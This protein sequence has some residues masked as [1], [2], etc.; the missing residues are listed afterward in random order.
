[1]HTFVHAQLPLHAES[2]Q[3]PLHRGRSLSVG[4][5]DLD[6]NQNFSTQKGSSLVTSARD[7]PPD[8]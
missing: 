4:A 6:D 7:S 1:M 8:V 5:D 2:S 3:V